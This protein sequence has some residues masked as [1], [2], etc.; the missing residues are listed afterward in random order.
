M[1][2]DN[3]VIYLPIKPKNIEGSNQNLFRSQYNLSGPAPYDPNAQFESTIDRV[4]PL[5]E[6][7]Y[8][9]KNI[10]EKMIDSSISS[11]SDLIERNITD[12]MFEFIDSNNRKE[13]PIKTSI[14]CWWCCHPFD[15]PPCAIPK[16]YEQGIF[17]LY[18]CFCSFNCA[19]AHNF[20]K[21]CDNM[22][23]SYSLLHLLIKKMYNKKY[24]KIIPSPPR[25]ALKIFGGVLTIKKYRKNLISNDILYRIIIP[26]MISI[27]P[28]LEENKINIDLIKNRKKYIPI[29]NIS[30]QMNSNTLKEI[31]SAK[32][33]Q[34]KKNK[35]NTLMAYLNLKLT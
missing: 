5:V 13:W 3:L 23:E 9:K 10:S 12:I 33:E 17:Y 14:Y 29:N 35:K 15:T 30:Q 18:G 24:K 11:S 2:E 16:K 28:K 27:V 19:A 26:P 4:D 22:W 32:T 7:V 6:Q 25:E 34:N 8:E 1:D 31:K 20:D 21:K